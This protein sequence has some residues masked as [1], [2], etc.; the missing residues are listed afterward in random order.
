[1]GTEVNLVDQKTTQADYLFIVCYCMSEICSQL[2]DFA[3]LFTVLP[4]MFS[5]AILAPLDASDLNFVYLFTCNIIL[6]LIGCDWQA[7]LSV[8]FYLEIIYSFD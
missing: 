1:M 4:D 8:C 2:I 6:L 5:F 3:P 7:A